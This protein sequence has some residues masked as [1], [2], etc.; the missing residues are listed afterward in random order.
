MILHPRSPCSERK[1]WFRSFRTLDPVDDSLHK[2]DAMS[3]QDNAPG[4]DA[5]GAHSEER[6][7]EPETPV[8][9]TLLGIAL[10]FGVLVLFLATRPAAPSSE[11]LV[12]AAQPPASAQAAAADAAPAPAPE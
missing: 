6:D 2:R 7:A 4:D 11:E 8:W 5:H 9:L 3:A 1:R 12:K 10:F